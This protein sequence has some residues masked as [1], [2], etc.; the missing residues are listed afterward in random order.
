MTRR[1][2][3]LTSRQPRS[4][5]H[6]PYPVQVDGSDE[7]LSRDA[8]HLGSIGALHGSEKD[9]YRT[10]LQVSRAEPLGYPVPG[11]DEDGDSIAVRS[12]RGSR[13]AS[14]FREHVLSERRFDDLVE[15]ARAHGAAHVVAPDPYGDELDKGRARRLADELRALRESAP[16]ALAPHVAGLVDVFEYCAEAPDDAWAAV[17]GP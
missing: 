11:G 5:A 12:H 10:S 13:R 8:D 2:S 17:V 15:L 4:L 3:P 6:P 1:P 9:H 14:V 7:R 16:E